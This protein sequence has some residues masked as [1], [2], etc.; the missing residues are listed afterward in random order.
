MATENCF[1]YLAVICFLLLLPDV[2]AQT[3]I[4]GTLRDSLSGMPAPFIQVTIYRYQSN[5]VSATTLSDE[6]GRYELIIHPETGTLFTLKTQSISFR[7]EIRHLHFA[8][9]QPQSKIEIDINLSPQIHLLTEAMVSARRAPFAL[10]GDTVTFQT[11]KW[12]S[13]TDESLEEVLKKIPGFEI[14][15]GG[16]I[17]VNG[18][19]VHKV[20]LNGAE[21]SD[22]GAGLITQHLSPDRVQS[23]EVRFDEK[24]ARLRESLL[25]TSDFVVMNIRLKSDFDP[26]LFGRL[27][28]SGG[29]SKNLMPGG[30]AKLFSLRAKTK[31][32]LLAEWEAFGQ[33]SIFL[34]HVQNLGAQALQQIQEMPADFTRMRTNPEFARELYGFQDFVQAQSAAVGLT[35]KFSPLPTLDLFIGTFNQ[36]DRSAQ[37]HTLRQSRLSIPIQTFEFEIG[38]S[39]ISAISRNKVEATLSLK[40]LKISYN[41]NNR[42]LHTHQER[43]QMESTLGQYDFR[44]V[45]RACSGYHNLFFEK[46]WTEKFG[47]QIGMVIQSG[48]EA[49]QRRFLHENSFYAIYFL[50][51]S[52]ALSPQVLT[53]EIPSRNRSGWLQSM[54]QYRGERATWQFGTRIS[55]Q[56]LQTQ[57][58][59]FHAQNNMLLL[60]NSQF[61]TNIQN[62]ALTQYQP[63]L[64]Y[65]RTLGPFQWNI[66]G[67]L[68]FQE[69]RAPIDTLF[70]GRAVPEWS[71]TLS[72]KL[73]DGGHAQFAFSQ[74]ASPLSM[75]P[76]VRGNELLDFQ[77]IL[78]P[79]R[80]T[81]K[82]QTERV[83]RFSLS[84]YALAH[85]GIALEFAGIRGISRA[86]PSFEFL[87]E[88][89]IAQ[90]TDQLPNQ[91]YIWVG[92]L[93]KVFEHLPIQLRMEGS[94][95]QN[96]QYNRYLGSVED[97]S[98]RKTFIRNI[99]F[100][101]FSAFRE[102][103]FQLEMKVKYSGFFFAA[104]G[105]GDIQHGQTIWNTFVQP[106]LR[107]FKERLWL[108][109]IVRQSTFCGLQASTLWLMDM[110]LNWI[111]P[112]SR[113]NVQLNNLWNGRS[114]Q[115]QE[116]N[117]VLFST[118]N[119]Q[120][121]GRNFKLQ[122]TWNLR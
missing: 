118:M 9:G 32:Q 101:I 84:T 120:I 54:F 75:H 26:G 13:A 51:D 1:G 12:T 27:L 77:S 41:F 48:L 122:Y 58:Q 119:R 82:P 66:I 91:Y 17:K 2:A 25:S 103:P 86:S 3:R 110:S 43:K 40:D 85:R 89:L 59:L 15:P 65:Q 29:Y 7:E 45:L 36:F 88:G 23:V 99:D 8:L 57:K 47:L 64:E 63:Y 69:I 71:S 121:F 39:A 55:N 4:S 46:K 100:R 112:G 22:G 92:K 80:Y 30:A 90:Y 115:T 5:A 16:G 106:K 18:K 78:I 114:F 35:G 70:S 60:N 102:G 56:F 97:L 28:A 113:W 24:D 49:D 10:K 108:E 116:I 6:S 95:I 105:V 117:Q 37:H 61:T 62:A 107:L 11:E 87:A 67:G 68:A 14:L 44:Q 33:K 109:G 52:S 81:M 93:A 53:Q 21:I 74:N 104:D 19:T 50:G 83:A 96:V 111:M 94:L 76:F 73:P 42:L 72:R 20:L 79:G 31:L 38:Q 34:E 98:K